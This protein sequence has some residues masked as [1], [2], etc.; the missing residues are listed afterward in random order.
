[1]GV[2]L[3]DDDHTASH[4]FWLESWA[5]QTP[6][7]I[8]LDDRLSQWTYGQVHELVLRCSSYLRRMGLEQGSIV[9]LDLPA[10]LYVVT[11]IALERLGCTVACYPTLLI[12][13]DFTF[14]LLLSSSVTESAIATHTWYLHEGAIETM[15]AMDFDPEPPVAT[16]AKQR[17]QLIFSSGSTGSPKA[18]ALSMLQLEKRRQRSTEYETDPESTF[19]GV[20]FSAFLGIRYFYL[21]L[22]HG[23][24]YLTPG[25]A[26]HNIDQIKK[27]QVTHI[28]MSP[29]QMRVLLAELEGTGDSLPLVTTVTVVGG[30]LTPAI[31]ERVGTLLSATLINLYGSTEFGAVSVRSYFSPDHTN[32]GG[33]LSGIELEIVNEADEPVPQG[34]TGV[35]RYRHPDE[36]TEYFGDP[37][38]TAKFFQDGWFYPGDRGYL[39]DN[40]ELHIV[41]RTNDAANAGGLKIDP[42]LFDEIA[43]GVIGVKDA[44]G[45]VVER[46]GANVLALAVVRTHGFREGELTEAMT[47]AFGARRPS[48]MYYLE[49][50]PRSGMGKVSRVELARLVSA[51]DEIT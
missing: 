15:L 41:G 46:G 35:V 5:K 33:V 24:T 7:R 51:A 39:S 44:A 6:S 21:A 19:C 10:P 34:I 26:S 47:H 16:T 25:V 38:T 9:A 36:S 4:W 12:G 3:Q 13:S 18:V 17:S 40:G 31:V 22:R 23:W 11:S 30:A 32:V 37:V 8:L 1:M 14:D 42:S 27:H 50:L 45:F 2:E 48:V 49:A 43:R 29:D 28:I 20:D